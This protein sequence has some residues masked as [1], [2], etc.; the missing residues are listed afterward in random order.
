MMLTAG[1]IV[2]GFIVVVVGGAAAVA[3]IY[4]RWGH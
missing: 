1:A 4:K 2:L 3:Y